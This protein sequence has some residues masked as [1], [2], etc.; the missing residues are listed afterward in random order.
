MMNTPKYKLSSL[1]TIILF[2]LLGCGTIYLNNNYAQASEDKYKITY[3]SDNVLCRYV[4]DRLDSHIPNPEGLINPFSNDPFGKIKWDLV[5]G[6]YYSGGIAN[7][8]IDNNGERETI[9]NGYNRDKR[10]Q[11]RNRST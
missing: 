11:I 4:K 5:S 10:I 2:T 6:P 9:L 3:S 8:D 7:L 1:F